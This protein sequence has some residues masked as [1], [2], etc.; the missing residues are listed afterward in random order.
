[1]IVA[2]FGFATSATGKSLHEAYLAASE[3]QAVT[4][5]ATATDKAEHPAFAELAGRLQLPVH[6]VPQAALEA[7]NTP[8]KSG[9]SIS[10]R[11]AGSV[12]E[13]AALAAAGPG[14]RLV[15]TRHISTDRRATCAV[16]I[17]GQT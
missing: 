13:A 6:S 11:G 8:T 5:L 9:R 2:G 16:A 12:A 10:E 15:S 17:G 3:G 7:I 4:A 14:A 1:M